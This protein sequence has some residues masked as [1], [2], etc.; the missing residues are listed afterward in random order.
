[1][2]KN[3]DCQNR[4]TQYHQTLCFMLDKSY[5]CKDMLKIHGGGKI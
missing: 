3:K 4:K 2:K 5:V 1:M